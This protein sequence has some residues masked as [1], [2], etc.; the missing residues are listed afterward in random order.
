MLLS[1]N[2]CATFVSVL[3]EHDFQFVAVNRNDFAITKTLVVNLYA[4]NTVRRAATVFRFGRIA[5][6][7]AVVIFSGGTFL[8]LW[9]TKDGMMTRNRNCFLVVSAIIAAVKIIDVVLMS[10]LDGGSSFMKREGMLFC[11]WP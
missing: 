6:A 3:V 7:V 8:F 9:Y 10:M 1:H 2:L 4:D 5:V 11:H